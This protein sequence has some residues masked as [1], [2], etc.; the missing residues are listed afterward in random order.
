MYRQKVRK[1]E[2]RN[3]TDYNNP[4][5]SLGLNNNNNNVDIYSSLL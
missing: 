4:L 3:E 5:L 2:G 1:R